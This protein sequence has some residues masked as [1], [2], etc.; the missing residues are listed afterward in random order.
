MRPPLVQIR[1][2]GFDDLALQIETQVVAGGE[3][4]EPLVA[5]ADHAT[6]DLLDH[7][8]AH[9]M[10]ASELVEVMKRRQPLVD[11]GRSSQ[12]GTP[13]GGCGRSH[14][15]TIGRSRPDLE[16]LIEP[17]GNRSQHVEGRLPRAQAL[18]GPY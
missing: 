16:G 1:R 10:R 4:R 2:D 11:P 14:L 17:R 3:V 12:R 15:G 9:G 8:I 7:R 6:V 13:A 5:H 18:E